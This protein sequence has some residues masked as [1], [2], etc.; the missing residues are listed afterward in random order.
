MANE[1]EHPV[2]G[3]SCIAGGGSIPKYLGMVVD[4]KDEFPNRYIRVRHPVTG[5]ETDY[6]PHNVRLVNILG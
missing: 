5:I 3:Q 6:A 4:W 2:I 1:F